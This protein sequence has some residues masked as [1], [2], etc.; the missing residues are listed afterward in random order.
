MPK[1]NVG[2]TIF[3]DGLKAKQVDEGYMGYNDT[4][5]IVEVINMGITNEAM[6]RVLWEKDGFGRHSHKMLSETCTLKSVKYAN[7][8]RGIEDVE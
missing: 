1:F 5:L 7:D 2:D 8:I 4:G 6:Y 3:Y